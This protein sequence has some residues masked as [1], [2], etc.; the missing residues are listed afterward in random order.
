MKRSQDC[1]FSQKQFSFCSVYCKQLK[2]RQ[3]ERGKGMRE[4]DGVYVREESYGMLRTCVHAQTN[5]IF[6]A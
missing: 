5:L 1:Y 4:M 3:W 2:T 6:V